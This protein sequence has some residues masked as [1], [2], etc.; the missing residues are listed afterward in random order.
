VNT[1]PQVSKL[2]SELLGCIKAE[3]LGL[4]ISATVWG[5]SN[6]ILF[7]SSKGDLLA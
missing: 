3:P 2:A 7:R 4:A 5:S 6:G 1:L